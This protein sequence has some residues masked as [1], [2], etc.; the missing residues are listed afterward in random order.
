MESWKLGLAAVLLALLILW[1]SHLAKFIWFLA[2]RVCTSGA[3]G[4]P[5][6]GGR[7]SNRA[8]N[9]PKHSYPVPPPL[10][11]QL[12]HGGVGGPEP[13]CCPQPSLY[14]GCVGGEYLMTLVHHDDFL[15][16]TI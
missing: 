10:V 12:K 13:G 16:M 5:S 15:G 6:G 9:R 11:E 2:L 14:T 7:W 8:S 4:S 1:P 3:A